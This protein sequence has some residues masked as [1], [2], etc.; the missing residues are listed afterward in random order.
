MAANIDHRPHRHHLTLYVKGSIY[1][2]FVPPNITENILHF[3]ARASRHKFLLLINLMHFFMY[4]FIHFISLH[5][6]EHHSAHH[7][8]IE[9]YV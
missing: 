5:D 7:Q 8:E 4:L 3:V 9:L 1:H 6:F 2:H